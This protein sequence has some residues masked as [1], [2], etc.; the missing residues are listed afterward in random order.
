M[1]DSPDN[2][3]DHIKKE[4]G[5]VILRITYGYTAEPHGRDP[6]VDMAGKTMQEFADATVPG[7]W[8]VD[9]M[10]FCKFI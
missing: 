4:A 1:L 9:I 10:P 6:L 7:K 2:L 8:V 5:T 3:F